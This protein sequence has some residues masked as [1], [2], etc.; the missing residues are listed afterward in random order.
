MTVP[1]LSI[2]GLIWGAFEL[3]VALMKRS[4]SD[5]AS[6]DR[7]S[8]F[9]IWAVCLS[10]IG[11][12]I[13]AAYRMPALAFP[14]WNLLYAAGLC[15]FTLGLLLRFYSIIYLGR[16]FTANVAIAK[17]HRLIDSG[18]YRFVRH[19]TYTG[20][21]MIALGLG[22]SFGNMASLLIIV[23]PILASLLWRIQIEEQALAEAFGEQYRSYMQR[24]KC[25]FPLIY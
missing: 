11:V 18:P 5:A 12:A 4:R 8:F 19:P 24:T 7:G 21:L 14:R 6:K 3:C 10:S 9:L 17:D 13:V 23:V 25:L 16:F 22:V 15:F 1:S 20:L 2:L